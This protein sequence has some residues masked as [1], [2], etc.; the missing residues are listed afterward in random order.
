[1]QKNPSHSERRMLAVLD[2]FLIV[3]PL[4]L[5]VLFFL[6]LSLRN[7]PD[8]TFLYTLRLYPVRE[9]YA[10]N[11]A[12]GDSLLDAVGKRLEIVAEEI[13]VGII[14]GSGKVFGRAVS[15]VELCAVFQ[16]IA[17]FTRKIALG[18]GIKAFGGQGVRRVGRLGGNFGC[19]K[20]YGIE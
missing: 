15:C 19:F 5:L 13:S 16:K 10:G 3:V 9:E 1:M 18:R 7:R 11:V 17:K 12:I 14:V 2:L 6:A 20:F 8:A 4:V